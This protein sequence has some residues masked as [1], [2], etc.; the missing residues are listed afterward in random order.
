M[1]RALGQSSP[2]PMEEQDS[3]LSPAPPCC[4]WP[5]CAQLH[6]RAQWP[7]PGP[8]GSQVDFGLPDG[9]KSWAPS[10]PPTGWPGLG[11][12]AV[13]GGGLLCGESGPRHWA[14]EQRSD[15]AGWREQTR[16]WG[17]HRDP[18]QVAA[19]VSCSDPFPA[20]SWGGGSQG[21][22]LA[23]WL[24]GWVQAPL[25]GWVVIIW[26]SQPAGLTWR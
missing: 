15:L 5:Q 8:P 10:P 25:P 4:L 7:Q 24:G 1:P 11:L 6:S 9:P 2:A 12:V 14:P 26:C 20:C 21:Q 16:G 19:Q 17:A 3:R 22:V 23:G 13:E 18:T